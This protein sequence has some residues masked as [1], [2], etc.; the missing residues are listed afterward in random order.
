MSETPGQFWLYRSDYGDEAIKEVYVR[1]E[2]GLPRDIVLV[3]RG[4]PVEVGQ[5]PPGMS[6]ASATGSYFQVRF[7]PVK[8]MPDATEESVTWKERL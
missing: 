6:P 3:R 2:S 7:K 5:L 1:H 8:P 4:K